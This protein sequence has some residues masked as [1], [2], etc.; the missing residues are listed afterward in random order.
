MR[1]GDER[2]EIGEG[3]LVYVPP[4]TSHSIRNDGPELLSYVSATSPPFGADSPG[5][6]ARW[7]APAD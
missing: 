5:A 7:L 6:S 3:T 2:R 1:V 4:G